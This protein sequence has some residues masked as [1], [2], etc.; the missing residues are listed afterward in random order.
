MPDRGGRSC[1]FV[2]RKN[3]ALGLVPLLKCHIGFLIFFAVGRPIGPDAARRER[4]RRPI[5]SMLLNG[6]CGDEP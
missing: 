6:G 4:V 3:D 2:R 5:H 1:T